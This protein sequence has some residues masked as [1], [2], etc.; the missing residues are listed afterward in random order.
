[1]SMYKILLLTDQQLKRDASSIDDIETIDR[2]YAALTEEDKTKYNAL[3]KGMFRDKYFNA[4]QDGVSSA[5]ASV[6]NIAPIAN[7]V[8]SL[9][10]SS[11]GFFESLWSYA[12]F[13]TVAIL[14][15]SANILTKENLSV[16][17]QETPMSMY[18]ILLMTDQQLKRDSSS[19]DDIETI[20]REY[21]ALTEEDKSKYNELVKGMFRDKYSN[22]AHDRTKV[23]E[24]VV[25]DI[26]QN[27][28]KDRNLQTSISKSSE[29][30]FL[31]KFFMAATFL[32]IGYSAIQ[33]IAREGLTTS[34]V[35]KMAPMSIYK[36]LLLT[37]QQLNRGSSP[38]DNLEIIDSEYATLTDEDK[39]KYN[40]LVKGMFRDKYSTAAYNRAKAA[41]GASNDIPQML[42]KM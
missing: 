34:L 2:E 23:A 17:L 25:V 6:A 38:V 32:V 35:D 28:D 10:K 15:V 16:A 3:V 41:E 40:A 24:G 12:K 26:T 39:A 33:L 7:E 18:K 31:T 19:T 13:L 42:T 29:L 27:G 14:L 5:V 4:A 1:M 9:Q 21:A 37:D 30:S 36:I 11:V 20:D 22:A 8:P